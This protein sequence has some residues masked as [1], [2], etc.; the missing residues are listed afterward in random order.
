VVLRDLGGELRERALEAQGPPARQAEGELGE[1]AR[2][3]VRHAVPPKRARTHRSRVGMKGA[4]RVLSA[5]SPL[6]ARRNCRYRCSPP[7]KRL[8]CMRLALGV[9]PRSRPPARATPRSRDPSPIAELRGVYSRT[10][11]TFELGTAMSSEQGVV[12]FLAEWNHRPGSKR[13]F[14]QRIC[15][16]GGTIDYF[17]GWYSKGNTG[18]EFDLP[19]LKESVQRGI[20]FWI[21]F[22]DK[23]VDACARKKGSGRVTGAFFFMWRSRWRIEA[24]SRAL[25]FSLP[26]WEARAA[27]P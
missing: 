10:H 15:S 7:G 21:D 1:R 18:E 19:F 17:I 16:S 23:R 24:R 13:D 2:P 12:E 4:A 25:S 6:R 27:C 5:S 3:L 8:T 11:C 22:Y 14:F 9:Q 20:G 26:R